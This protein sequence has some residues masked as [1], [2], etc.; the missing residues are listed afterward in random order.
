MSPAF[1][2]ERYFRR[3]GYTGPREATLDVLRAVHALHPLAIPFENLEPILGRP[4]HVD[5]PS[6]VAKLVDARRGGYCFEQNALFASA[7][8]YLGFTVTPLIGRV[9]WGRTFDVEAPLTHMMLRVDLD[10]QAWLADVGFGSVTLTAPLRLDSP[11]EQS[12]P[13]EAFRLTAVRSAG[14]DTV[15]E[16]QLS[17]RSAQL[18]LPTYR[19]TPRPAEWIDYKLGNW[20]TSSAPDSIFRNHLIACRVLPEGRIALLDTKLIERAAQGDV[21]AETTITSA[22]QLAEVLGERFGLNLDGVDARELF[23]TARACAS[24]SGA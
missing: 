8:T 4:V 7:L 11:D 13:L 22:S 9:V 24:K 19:F 5:L 17:V 1:D 21:L 20:Y 2:P 10:G 16:Y 14:G 15:S 12:T 3:I 6:V 23:E 18:W